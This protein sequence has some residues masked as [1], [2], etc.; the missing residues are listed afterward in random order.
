MLPKERWCKT[1]NLRMASFTYT[2][3]YIFATSMSTGPVAAM[4]TLFEHFQIC[5]RKFR[6]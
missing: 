4:R 1:Y 3:K 2:F 6:S 5:Y